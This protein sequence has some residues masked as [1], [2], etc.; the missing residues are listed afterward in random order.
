L[1]KKPKGFL[2]G[3]ATFVSGDSAADQRGLLTWR[4]P[5]QLKPDANYPAGFA[6]STEWQAAR[7]TRLANGAPIFGAGSTATVAKMEFGGLVDTVTRSVTVSAQGLSGQNTGADVLTLEMNG[8][9]G[10]FSG[11]YVHPRDGQK[12]PIGGALYQKLTIGRGT[13][14]GVGDASQA[15]TGH[16]MLEP[17]TQ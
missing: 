16:W 17:S 3:E 7:Y 5:A 15:V 1:Y 11:S 9:N 8:K 6:G 2:C 10:L 13:F 14:T 12:H 4:K